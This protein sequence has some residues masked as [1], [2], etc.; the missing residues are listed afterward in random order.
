MKYF[1]LLILAFL[2]PVLIQAQCPE[3]E[4][5]PECFNDDNLAQTC[6][7]VMPAATAGEYYEE[8]MTFFMPEEALDPETGILATLIEISVTAVN[9]LPFGLEYTAS[10]E[11]YYPSQ[12]ENFGCASICG[13]PLLPGEY[14]VSITTHVVAEAF[15][16]GQELDMTYV[17]PFTVLEGEG[18]NNT[19]AF[20]QLAG[21]GTVDVNFEGL[22]NGDPL[23]T[24]WSW[25]FGNGNSSAQQNP[26]TQTYTEV[27]EH[28][29]SLQT[30][31]YDYVLTDVSVSSVADGWSGDIEE[32]TTLS[33][34]DIYFVI[35]NSSNNVVYTSSTIDDSQSGTW[36]DLSVILTDPPYSIAFYDEDTIS[37]NDYLGDYDITLIEGVVLFDADGTTG[38]LSIALQLGDTFYDEE[39]INVF[40]MP[41]TEFNINEVVNMLSYS[42]TTL[43]AFQWYLNDEPIDGA[44][45]NFIIMETGGVFHCVVTNTY[46]CTDVSDPYTHCPEFEV[47][48]DNLTG[49]FSIPQGFESYQWYFNGL[50]ID[51]ATSYFVNSVGDGNYAVEITTDYDCEVMSEVYVLSIIG[52]DIS[53][54]YSFNIYPVP[55]NGVLNIDLNYTGEITCRVYN[56][57]GELQLERT[58]I[59]VSGNTSFISLNE[60]STG[61]YIL[62]LNFDNQKLVKHFSRQ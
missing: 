25:D 30:N 8:Y 61:S 60:L 44:I 13:V 41:N 19:F 33:N 5:D 37:E 48:Y 56:V 36:S 4:V 29:V 34:P 3:C 57:V 27:G 40:P 9:G 50:E 49:I 26:E 7:E 58:L 20:D 2:T 21:C 22:I 32:L 45:D 52:S 54:S 18:G 17:T 38:S 28:V 42:D 10:S 59:N 31:I 46:N 1:Y 55:S 12:G 14:E 24:T 62:E 47:E 15:G 16:I 6:P 11:V 53:S 39:I 43:I 23:P 51:G 35:L